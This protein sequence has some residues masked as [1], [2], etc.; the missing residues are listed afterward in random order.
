LDPA[1][2]SAPQRLE[3]GLPL[4]RVPLA[5]TRA[6]TLLIAFAAGSRYE[7]PDESGVAHFLEHLVF[8]GGE[9]Y[10]DVRAIN[11][12]AERLGARMNAFTSAELVAFHITVRAERLLEAAE[13][14][15]DFLGNPRL[16]PDELER[17]RGV[18][19]QEIARSHDQPGSLADE[20]IDRAAYGDHPLGRPILGT[21]ESVGSLS[22]D[23][24][25]GFRRRHWA[26]SRGGAF[27]VGNLTGLENGGVER[28]LERLPA[29]EEAAEG[30]QPPR[31]R[32]LRTLVEPRD[33]KQSHLRVGYRPAIDVSKPGNRAA[34]TI[35]A[36]LLG[37]SMGS[38][39]V[40]EIRERRGLAYSVS[41]ADYTASDDPLL[42][43]SAGLKS[44]NCISAYGRMREIVEELAAEGPTEEEVERVRAFAAGRRILSFESTT[45][46]ARHAAQERILFDGDVSPD[47]EIARLDDVTPDQV[48]EVARAV[49]G[50][51]AVA[52]VGPHEV[53]EFDE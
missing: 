18:V 12:T 13:L 14:L 8:Q 24:V 29:V 21:E 44:A 30:P 50:K 11:W 1:L 23:E 31:D 38:R 28:L 22:R 51:P 25:L 53:E 33:S 15:T 4:F 10:P 6:A 39:L 2:R 32:T 5:G 37:G 26:G 41:A 7:Q 52:C 35:Y 46:V 42:Q 16:D 9:R 3:N 40:D 27:L 49:G 45:A 34:L 48:A 47:A 43:L 19:T 17:E 36:T 20:L